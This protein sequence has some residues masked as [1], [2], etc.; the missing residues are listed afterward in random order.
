[1]NQI[2]RKET[3]QGI[4]PAIEIRRAE[5]RGVANFGWL[6]S[7]HTFSFGHYYDPQQ[8]GFSD[9]LVINDDQVAPAGGFGAHPHADM[10]IVSYVLS[11]ALEHKDSMG[12]G[13]IIRPGDV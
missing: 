10:E 13:S 8:L 12:T 2:Q 7:R 11:G 6:N 5:E 1:M 4:A 9:L 3:A